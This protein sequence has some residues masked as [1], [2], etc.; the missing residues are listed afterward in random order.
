MARELL[1]LLGGSEG[2]FDLVA[3]E[4]VPAAGGREAMI[5]LL[6]AFAQGWEDHLAEYI[7]PWVRRG[8][9]RYYVI[10]PD[11]HGN[12]DCDRASVQLREATGI[13]I[14]GGDTARYHQLYATEPIRSLLRERY[15]AGVPVAGLSAG[16]LIRPEVCIVHEKTPGGRRPRVASGLGL[17]SDLLV[18][19]HFS[20]HQDSLTWLLDAMVA[21]RLGLGLG[22]DS[23]A[24]AMLV[25]GEVQRALG[26][27]VH[28]VRMTDFNCGTYAVSVL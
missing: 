27:S 3:D 11:E 13:F 17:V 16:A 18:E 7:D 28:A 22:I 1:F 4:F 5:A 24:C 14:G 23:T 20:D 25:D 10:T 9:T 6:F 26:Q 12:L 2:T 8:A 19:V 21:T 15:Q